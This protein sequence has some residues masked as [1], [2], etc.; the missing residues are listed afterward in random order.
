MSDSPET[1]ASALPGAVSASEGGLRPP[2]ARRPSYAER[3]AER[4]ARRAAAQATAAQVCAQLQEPNIP[5]VVRLVDLFGP[6]LIEAQAAQAQQLIAAAAAGAPPH[7]VLQTRTGQ[8]RTTG[9]V[10]FQLMQEHATG[11]GIH[12]PALAL[13]PPPMRNTERGG[14]QQEKSPPAA[15]SAA[16]PRPA[17]ATLAPAPPSVPSALAAPIPPAASG[18]IPA[19][20]P[21]RA[22]LTV[23]GSLAGPPQDLAGPTGPLVELR[24]RCEMTPTLPKGLPV[25]GPTPVAVWCTPKQWAKVCNDLTGTTG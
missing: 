3:V 15:A 23:V 1:P 9:G 17:S 21:A 2:G 25:L 10:F 22:K 18:P 14:R 8:P 7:P 24:F 12:W 4:T 6:E 11:L 19:V 13:P 20:R 5:A 16:G